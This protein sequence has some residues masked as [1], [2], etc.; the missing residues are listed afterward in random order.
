MYD[1]LDKVLGMFWICLDTCLDMFSYVYGW[2]SLISH[3]QIV[4][5]SCPLI[6]RWFLSLNA[7]AS[8]TRSSS[9]RKL[10]LGYLNGGCGIS[11]GPLNHILI[12]L[13]VHLVEIDFYSHGSSW[14]PIKQTIPPMVPDDFQLQVGWSNK[15]DHTYPCQNF[16]E[17][18]SL[19]SRVCTV[20]TSDPTVQ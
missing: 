8:P 5:L 18:M 6:S 17:E 19:Y 14:F 7:W 11:S 12:I 1:C 13:R 10:N 3:I 2:F 20:H 15:T 9:T 16:S 4:T